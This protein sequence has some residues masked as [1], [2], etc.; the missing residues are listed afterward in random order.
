M[1]IIQLNEAEEV[2][3]EN[4]NDYMV[5]EQTWMKKYRF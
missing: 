2:K 3:E 5:N 1:R 4:I